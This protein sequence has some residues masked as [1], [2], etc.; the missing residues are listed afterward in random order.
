VPL[1]P[2]ASPFPPIPSPPS[3]PTQNP[4]DSVVSPVPEPETYAMMAL[5]LALVGWRA[6]LK[7][8]RDARAKAA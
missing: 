1:P 5:G 8:L 4:L 2:P 6:R 3:G 7:A